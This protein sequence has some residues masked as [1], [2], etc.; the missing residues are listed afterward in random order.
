MTTTSKILLIIII[1]S[2]CVRKV[3]ETKSSIEV[4]TYQ[5]EKS[6]NKNTNYLEKL[7]SLNLCK[8]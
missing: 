5:Y 6:E 1:T 7:D 4:I 2:S 8:Q 3:E